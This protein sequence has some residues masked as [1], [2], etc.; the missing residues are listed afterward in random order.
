MLIDIFYFSFVTTTT[1]TVSREIGIYFHG[2]RIPTHIL[3]TEVHVQ[4]VTS[5]LSSTVEITPTPTWKTI[6]LTPTI[7]HP[8]PPPP[9]IPIP[10]INI[11]LAKQRQDQERLALLEKL[12]NLKNERQDLPRS[13]G[14][15]RAHVVEIP[16]LEDSFPSVKRYLEEI[17]NNNQEKQHRIVAE[18][19]IAPPSTSI[20]TVFISGSVPGQYSTSLLTISLDQQGNQVE[21]Q[22]R[23]ISPTLSH[24]VEATLPVNS[25]VYESD[26]ELLGSFSEET[27]ILA[28]STNVVDL[29]TGKTLTVTVTRTRTYLP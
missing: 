28:D 19:L 1:V 25:L 5:S 23:H 24:A 13:F 11:Q 15:F 7:T 17:R 21:R 6:T 18:P 10:D 29:C 22:R 20:S 3:D 12:Q 26:V 9:T 4:T 27:N 2:R 14:G 8:P 16:K